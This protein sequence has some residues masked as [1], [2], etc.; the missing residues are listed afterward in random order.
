M[1]SVVLFLFVEPIDQSEQF[2]PTPQPVQF[3]LAQDF[4][5]LSTLGVGVFSFS[6][7]SV[8]CTYLGYVSWFVV[9]P[10]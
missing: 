4:D 7:S 9:Y 8:T 1:G 3:D 5:Q 10:G 2:S 6:S